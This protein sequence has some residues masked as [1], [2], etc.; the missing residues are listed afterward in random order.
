MQLFE[1]EGQKLLK[2]AKE[3]RKRSA[4]EVERN[5]K[6]TEKLM[7]KVSAPF[8]CTASIKRPH[9]MRRR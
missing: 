4:E 2:A 8:S 1:N 9:L 7:A 5:E 3:K 6:E